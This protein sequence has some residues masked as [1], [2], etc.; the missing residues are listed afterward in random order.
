M[1]KVIQGKFTQKNDVVYL[2]PFCET[3]QG[4]WVDEGGTITCRTCSTKQ[5]PPT[6]WLTQSLDNWKEEESDGD[7]DTP[8]PLKA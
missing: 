7:D 6:E 2:C 3:G 1:G 5:L 4:F 8:T